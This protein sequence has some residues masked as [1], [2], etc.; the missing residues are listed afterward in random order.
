MAFRIQL[1]ISATANGDKCHRQCAHLVDM[2]NGDFACLVFGLHL[3]VDAKTRQ[4][5][6][7][8]GCLLAEK[9]VSRLAKAAA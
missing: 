4:I 8:K 1:L 7:F 5:S 9:R 3:P 2:E 6:R